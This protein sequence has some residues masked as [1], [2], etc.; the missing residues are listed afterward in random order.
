MEE[1]K[2]HIKQEHIFNELVQ[3]YLGSP[4][5][6]PIS[7]IECIHINIINRWN[8]DDWVECI[9]PSWIYRDHESIENLET[10]PDHFIF[11]NLFFLVILI[12]DCIP[13]FKQFFWFVLEN[14][15]K[16][17][18]FL[19][20][21]HFIP[22]KADALLEDTHSVELCLMIIPFLILS[23]LCKQVFICQMLGRG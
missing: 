10:I 2:D 21:G 6:W 14:G 5:R 9:F 8:N 18:K 19:G 15:L 11:L 17:S 13:S 3:E 20:L 22:F 12:N 1:T 4:I 23:G 7:C 16:I